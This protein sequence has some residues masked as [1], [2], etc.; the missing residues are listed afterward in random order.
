MKE[1]NIDGCK[2]IGTGAFGKVYKIDAD[3][4]IKVYD[5]PAKLPLIETE[6]ERSRRAFI[7][8]IPT[9]IPFGVARVGETYG[10][11]FELIDAV[12]CNDFIASHPDKAGSIIAEYAGFIRRIHAVQSAPGEFPDARKIYSAYLEDV[13]EYLPG[14]IYARLH[15]FV[16]AVP[17]S[18][19][20]VHGDIQMKNVMLS[21][22]EMF[23]ID[24]S[25]LCAGSQLF[26]FAGLYLTYEAFTSI[27]GYEHQEKFLGLP[28]ELANR[29]Y[30]RTAELFGIDG[31]G[32]DIQILAWLRFLHV[33][34]LE[35]S[36]LETFRI[37]QAVDKLKELLDEKM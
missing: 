2:L 9:A 5:D 11:M 6:Q 19:G 32:R 27:Y 20:L 22:G 17:E 10:S 15:D 14:E 21:N 24:M 29:I 23:L 8:G 18:L 33:V 37:A 3:T 4:V 1:I 12:N 36:P 26:E 7:K 28:I 30:Y 34:A 35:L 31:N 25:T 16:T 13:R